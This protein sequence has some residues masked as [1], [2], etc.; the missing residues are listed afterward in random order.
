M[1]KTSKKEAAPKKSIAADIVKKAE[2]RKKEQ[3]KAAAAAQQAKAEAEATK[4]GELIIK[5]SMEGHALSKDYEQNTVGVISDMLGKKFEVRTNGGGIKD[6]VKLTELEAA[7]AV[8]TMAEI[9]ERND[10]VRGIAMLVL[11]GIVI[12]IKKQFGEDAGEYLIQQAVSVT[13]KSKHSCGD[14]ERVVGWAKK[15]FKD[16]VPEGLSYTHLQELKNYSQDKGGNAVIEAGEVRK[17]AKKVQEGKVV[18]PKLSTTNGKVV[19]QRKILSCAE[20]RDL[21]KEARGDKP[22]APSKTGKYFYVDTSS[23]EV[24]K[25]KGLDKEAAKS[26]DYIVIDAKGDNVMSAKGTVYASIGELKTL[27]PKEEK[28]EEPKAEKPKAATKKKEAKPEA[29]VEDLS[30]IP[31]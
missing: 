27:E 1:S 6:G 28:A 11:G 16:E 13:G 29:K 2:A 19:E 8:S 20:T 23:G 18:S 14:S 5:A 30:M 21:L 31:D 9:T 7:K 25:S 10:T 15:V 3:E 17:I 26:G 24:F 12:D 22:S 4:R